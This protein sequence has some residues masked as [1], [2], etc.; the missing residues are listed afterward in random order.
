MMTS[1]ATVAAIAVVGDSV[2]AATG[3]V[4]V[5]DHLP[6]ASG[7]RLCETT[8]SIFVQLAAKSKTPKTTNA[9]R[10][11]FSSAPTAQKKPATECCSGLPIPNRS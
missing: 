5:E 11:N 4:P 2:E 7:T 8:T 9:P 1:K 3:E 10:S 6:M